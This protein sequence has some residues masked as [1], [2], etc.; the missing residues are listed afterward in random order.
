M[1]RLVLFACLGAALLGAAGLSAWHGQRVDAVAARAPAVAASVRNASSSSVDDRIAPAQ[2][3]L[4]QSLAG[5]NAP[6][7][8]LDEHGH[9]A[10]VRA[11]R[12]FFDYCLSA[13]SDLKPEALD[14]LVEREIAAQLDDTP[15]QS[16]ALD[17][18]NR[19]RRY[20]KGLEE[21]EKGGKPS[22]AKLDSSRPREIDVQQVTSVLAQREMLATRELGDWADAFFGDE[23]AVQRVDAARLAI[24]Q[25]TSLS[26]QQKTGHM[27]ALDQRLPDGERAERAEAK[28]KQ[29]VIDEVARAQSTNGSPEQ[30]RDALTQTLGADAAERVAQVRRDDLAWQAKYDAYAAQRAQIDA[31]ALTPQAR[32]QS[33]QQLRDRIFTEPGEAARAAS[34][35]RARTD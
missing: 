31:S 12:E 5:S 18:W 11:A 22:D 2:R 34:F 26:A 3:G 20:L 21:L 15:A 27:E 33:I 13:Q 4:P 28:R 10:K 7:L 1:A 19:Y 8:P 23:L 9:L 16:E 17:V 29:E 35:D 14:A 32:E 30:V 6:R 25:D 24:A